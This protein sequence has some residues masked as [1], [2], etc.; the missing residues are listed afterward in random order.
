MKRANWIPSK[1]SFLFQKIQE[2]MQKHEEFWT[3][4][5][6]H[7]NDFKHQFI[8]KLNWLDFRRK[9]IKL[10]LLIWKCLESIYK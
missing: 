8:I 9:S 5:S 10:M 2:Y 3:I 6:N 1:I 7:L 4:W